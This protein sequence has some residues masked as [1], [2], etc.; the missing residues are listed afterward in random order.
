M[1]LAS[2][3][4][5]IKVFFFFIYQVFSFLK[6]IHISNQILKQKSK[7]D[8]GNFVC[9]RFLIYIFHEKRLGKKQKHKTD[10]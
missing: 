10:P 7:I 4:L 2:L 8:F 1:P 5:I 6:C 9:T 3:R